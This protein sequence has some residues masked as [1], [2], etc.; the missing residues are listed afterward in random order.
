MNRQINLDALRVFAI[1]GVISLHLLGGVETL[2]LTIGNRLVVNVILAITYTSVNLFGLLSG[3]LKI[4]RPNHF[5][6]MLKIIFQTAF[7]CVVITAI[8]VAF[9][10]ERNVGTII[11]YLCPFMGDRLWYITC[12]FFV[13]LCAPF[14]NLLAQRLK[15]ADYKKLLVLLMLLMSVIT[16]VCFK[17]FFH[18]VSHGYSVG[19]LIYMYLLG[20]YFK[21]YGF[22]QKT[23]KRKALVGLLFGVIAIV[24]SKFI[25]EFVLTKGGFNTDKSWILYYYSSPLTLMNSIILFYLFVSKNWK[26]NFFGKVLT[27]LSTVS[28]GVYIIHAHP[29]SLDHILIGENLTWVVKD[30]PILTLIII[31]GSVMGILVSLSVVECIRMKFFELCGIEKLTKFIG[32]K[33]DKLFAIERTD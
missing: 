9:L 14:L 27:W 22:G 23:I 18:V 30:N 33:V 4:D 19:W 31:V 25:L 15:Q 1:I 2:E 7:W 26:D 8:C 21:K 28:L 17:D 32:L 20:G 11:K 5:S 12:Y 3:Y 29:Y 24:A 10:N 13:F 6:S 16:T